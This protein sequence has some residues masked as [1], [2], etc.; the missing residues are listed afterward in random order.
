MELLRHWRQNYR[1]SQRTTNPSYKMGSDKFPYDTHPDYMC[2]LTR[3]DIEKDL[4]DKYKKQLVRK[5]KPAVP[6]RSNS[7]VHLALKI[8]QL[9]EN[10]EAIDLNKGEVT[11]RTEQK[12]LM[13]E[14]QKVNL[15]ISL[16]RYCFIVLNALAHPNS[17]D[18]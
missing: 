16:R 4:P 7:D 10:L 3:E 6:R 1:V 12:M 8:K 14:I 9:F 13:S 2:L 5:C 11:P 17:E 18:R 15:N